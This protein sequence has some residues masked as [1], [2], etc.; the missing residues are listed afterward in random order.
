MAA[1]D[2]ERNNWKDLERDGR[3]ARKQDLGSEITEL[4]DLSHHIASQFSEKI[5]GAVGDLRRPGSFD[6]VRLTPQF[7]QDDSTFL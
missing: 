7:A 1:E 3:K 4:L 2:A 6:F 5:S